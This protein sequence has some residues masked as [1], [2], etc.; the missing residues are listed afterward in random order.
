MQVSEDAGQDLM[1]RFGNGN[2]YDILLW[3]L[4]ERKL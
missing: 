2:S 3:M 4:E 1:P